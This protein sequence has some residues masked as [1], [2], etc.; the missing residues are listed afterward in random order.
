[1]KSKAGSIGGSVSRCSL[2]QYRKNGIAFGYSSLKRPREVTVLCLQ[3][4]ESFRAGHRYRVTLHPGAV[5]E[6]TYRY[7]F[8]SWNQLLK[9]FKI[10]KDKK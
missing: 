4:Y 7:E 2:E 6:K 3:D 10:F 9:V 5:I 8:P 1:M